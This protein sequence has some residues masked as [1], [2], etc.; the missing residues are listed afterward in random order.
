[1]FKIKFTY[2]DGKEYYLARFEWYSTKRI[3]TPVFSIE[4]LSP[5]QLFKSEEIAWLYWQRNGKAVNEFFRDQ[6][7]VVSVEKESARAT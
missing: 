3:S 6:G 2:P 5:A 1:M 4:G 7:V